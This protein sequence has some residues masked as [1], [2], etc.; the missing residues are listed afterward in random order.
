MILKIIKAAYFCVLVTIQLLLKMLI[1]L[2]LL[3]I[4]IVSDCSVF[5][6]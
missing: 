3:H 2:P 4:Y 5:I 6:I 1:T